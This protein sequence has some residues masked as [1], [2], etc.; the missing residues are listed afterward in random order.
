MLTVTLVN[1]AI[2]DAAGISVSLQQ[3]NNTTNLFDQTRPAISLISMVSDS[4]VG[5]TF[6]VPVF[7][8]NQGSGALDSAD[9]TLSI[10]GG[11]AT[12]LS[13]MPTSVSANGNTYTLGVSL[14]GTPDG[15]EVLTVRP[16]VGLSLIQHLTLPTKR[17]V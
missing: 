2:Y 1:S 5:V 12:L 3:S 13:L 15:N 11:M 9:F 14:S 6:S 7:S 4:A 16:A 17:I 10:E 8:T